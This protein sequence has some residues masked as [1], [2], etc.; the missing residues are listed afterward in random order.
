MPADEYT[1][2]AIKGSTDCDLLASLRSGEGRFGWSYI[3]T[4]DLSQLKSRIDSAGWNSLRNEEK[5]CYQ[6]FLLELRA[7]DYVVYV[8]VPDWGQCS[9][10]RVTGPYVWRY[11]G[12]G[13]D[14]NH[15]FPVDP[16]SVFV[17]DR[18]DAAVHPAL[19]ARLI[20]RGRYWRIYAKDEFEAL[21]KAQDAGL[22]GKPRTPQE[23]LAFLAKEMEP[24][25]RSIT[26]KIHHTHPNYDLEALVAEM[27]T[28][29]PG[30]RQVKPQGGAGDHGADILVVFESG[31]PIAGLQQQR[32]CVV[33][34]KSFT[35]EHWDTQAVED[36]RRAFEHYPEADT[37]LI[38]STAAAASESFDKALEKMREDT[39][40][41][42]AL[43]I[44]PDVAAFFLRFG[45]HPT[46]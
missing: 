9:A 27:F 26:E 5:D 2:Y 24:L 14:F 8:N 28:K 6:S 44:G 21:L 4:A 3:E 46:A 34:V 30:V 1:I 20:L 22:V 39:G 15:R 45:A 18:N 38:I 19:R 31:L 36:I 17:F 42:V 10:A 41:S 7:D 29:V 37:G 35:G 11:E 25:L 32:T 23:N 40:K 13:T 33:Q 16:K 43:L 12:A